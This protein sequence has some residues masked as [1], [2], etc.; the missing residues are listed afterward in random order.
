MQTSQI[1]HIKNENEEGLKILELMEQECIQMKTRLSRL[2]EHN[3]SNDVVD[4]AE[5]LQNQI[6]LKEEAIILIRQ[7]FKTQAQR[8]QNFNIPSGH[9]T[10]QSLI[11]KQEQIYKQINYLKKECLQMQ[12]KFNEYVLK[13]MIQS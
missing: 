3:S 4:K 2:L 10:A 5:Q 7:D 11:E 1:E 12:E 13:Y 8:I 9:I 6:L